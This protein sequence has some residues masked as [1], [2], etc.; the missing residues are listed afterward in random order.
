MKQGP[1]QGGIQDLV[2]QPGYMEV[3]MTCIVRTS[4]W[5]APEVCLVRKW[6]VLRDQEEL[7]VVNGHFSLWRAEHWAQRCCCCL[8]VT[9]DFPF[10]A[11]VTKSQ[12]TS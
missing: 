10:C 1:R 5:P 2:G 11:H 4:D 9:I 6:E 12:A 3:Q 7:H 8:S